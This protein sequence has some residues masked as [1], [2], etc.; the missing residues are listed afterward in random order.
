LEH[1][2]RSGE[3]LSGIG[4][5]YRVS[6]SLLRA[7]NGGLDP[8]RLRIGARLVI[9][10]NGVVRR[11]SARTAGRPGV[12]VRDPAPA[13]ATAPAASDGTHLVRGGETVWL[14]AQRYGLRVSDIKRWND[15]D[16]TT[17]IKVGERLRVSPPG[18][19]AAASSSR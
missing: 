9:P 12:A 7:A 13:A 6:V 18:E 8:R 3:T 19:P 11:G 1:V 4:Q 2:V 17:V 14:I 10:V 5:R 16:D 15:L